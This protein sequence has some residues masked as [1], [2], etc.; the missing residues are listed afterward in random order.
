M[1]KPLE[2]AQ[3]SA[4]WYV[5]HLGIEWLRDAWRQHPVRDYGKGWDE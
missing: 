3:S 4:H 1:R 5:E 2:W